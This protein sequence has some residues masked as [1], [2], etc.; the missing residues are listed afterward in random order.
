MSLKTKLYGLMAA[1]MLLLLVA[2]Q[3]GAVPEPGPGAGRTTETEDQAT[4]QDDA[5]AEHDHNAVPDLTMNALDL[6]PVELAAGEKLRVVATTNIIGDMVQNVAGDRVKLNILIP[7][8]SDPHTFQPA[9][10]D[11]ASVA[12]AHLVLANGLN[13]EEFL[14]E[15]IENAGG[16]AAVIRVAEGVEHDKAGPH[17]QKGVDPH[18]W[19]TPYNALVYVHNIEAALSALNPANADTYKAKA[20]AY[21]AKLEALDRWV[22]DQVETIPPDKRTMVTDHEAFSYYADRYGLDIIGAVI[23]AYSTAAEPSAQELAKLEETITE[24]NV[25]A[26]FVGATVNPNLAERVAAD[27]GTKLVPLYTGSLGPEGSGAATYLDFIR[28]NTTAI[29]EGLRP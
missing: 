14:D 19:M 5:V 26:I 6:A 18:A 3:C 10:Q 9:P 16:K 29:V 27:T 11:V 21:E 7:G 8:G 4:E 13:F 24:F 22:F 17:D 1:F 2:A 12:D 23:P 20:E 28:Y 25:P 15:L